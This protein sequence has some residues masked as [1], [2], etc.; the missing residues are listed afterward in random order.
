[1]RFQG[2]A[3]GK[4]GAVADGLSA[5]ALLRRPVRVRGIRLGH[6]ADL[7]LDVEAMRVVGLE[8]VC[9][10]D[11]RRFLPLG[12]ARVEGSEIAVASPLHLLDGGD[13]GFYRRRG[14]WLSA[15]RGRPVTLAGRP[16]GALADVVV[17]ADGRVTAL[18]LEAREE[19]APARVPVPAGADLAIAAA[20]ASAA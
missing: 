11:A 3:D 1:M 13:L 4:D 8:V 19:G 10:D 2:G 9:G 18:E 15:L 16:A 6:P 20:P 14:R 5:D 7:L 17:G 12:A